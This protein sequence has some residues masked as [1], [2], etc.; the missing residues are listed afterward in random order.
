MVRDTIQLET[1]VSTISQEY[2]LEFIS[3]Y[4]ITEDLHPEL[5]VL[6]DRIVDFP[7]DKVGVYTKFFEFANFRIPISKFRFDIL[8]HYQ[9]H[10]SQLSVIGT[11]KQTSKNKH[12]AVLYQTPGFPKEL[13]QLDQA[14]GIVASEVPPPENATTMGVAPETDLG[15]EVAATGRCLRDVAVY[16]HFAIST[17]PVKIVIKSSAFILEYLLQLPIRLAFAAIFIKIGVIHKRGNDGADANAPPK[18]LRKDHAASRLIQSTAG[19]KSLALVGLETGFAFPV[20]APQ[21]TPADASDPDPLSYANPQSIPERDVAQSSKGA[22]VAGD[23]ESDNTSFTSMV[24]SPGNI[25]QPGWGVTKGYRLDTPEACQDL[26]DHLAPPRYFSELRHL[27]N[28]DFLGKYNINLARQVAMGSQL[29]LRFKQEAKLLKKYVAQVARRDQRIQASENEIKNL[30]ALLEAETDMKKAAEA[31]NAKLV[32]E[33]E[34]LRAQFTD[35]QV[36]NDWLSQ[37]VS[38][39]QAQVTGEEKF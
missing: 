29:R 4:G 35:L 33:L 14:Q 2:L 28:D 27:P 37:Q 8:G 26:V 22:T 23:P 34:S 24:E 20:P 1:A 3:E 19:G 16:Y 18:V 6:V 31:K 21:E 7:E 36:S 32:K 38:T 10:L 39:L 17:F 13:E 5:S 25:Y 15:E 12:P 9:I 11:T 30:E